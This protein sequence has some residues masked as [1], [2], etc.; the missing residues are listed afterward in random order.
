MI[1]ESKENSLKYFLIQ[2]VA[3]VIFLASILNQSFSFLIPFALLIK[4]GAAPFHMWLVSI[5]KSMSWKVLSLLMTFQKIGP[6]L[7]LAML[8]SVSHLSWLMVNMSSFLLML[9]YYVTYLAIL[10]FAVILLQQT[11]MYSL[12]QMNS[13]AS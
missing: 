10:Y 12:A 13:N 9:V 1:E 6:L 7:G 3:S 2:S 8:S 5:S 4:I 11:P